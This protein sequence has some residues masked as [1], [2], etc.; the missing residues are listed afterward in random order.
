MK[1]NIWSEVEASIV[2]FEKKK[3]SSYWFEQVFFSYQENKAVLTVPSVFVK[4]SF[5]KK[6]GVKVLSELKSRG[7]VDGYVY[8]VDPDMF[9]KKTVGKD[10]GLRTEDPKEVALVEGGEPSPFDLSFFDRFCVGSSNKLAV[11]AAKSIVEKPGERFNPLFLYGK[12][13]VGKTYLLKTIE[14]T[15]EDAFYIGSEEFLNSFIQGIKNKELG[16]FKN[17]VRNNKILLFDDVQFLIG[18]KAAS[19]E[20][21]NT[22]NHYIEE[23]KSIVLVSDVRPEDLSGFPERLVSR[24]YSGLVTDI[25]KPGKDVLLSYLNKKNDEV[26]LSEELV[27]K[28]SSYPFSNFREI[29]GFLN[30]FS[31]SVSANK[32]VFSFVE[33]FLSGSS[34]SFIKKKSPEDLLFFVSEKYQVDKD[35]LVSKNRSEA[36]VKARHILIAL[37]RQNT[38]LSLNQIGLFLGGRSHSTVLSSLKKVEGSKDLSTDLDNINLQERVG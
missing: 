12:P 1:K 6:F 7:F 24:I 16:G 30:S 26:K 11:V 35:L 5:E 19:E 15:R 27:A 38:D 36:V 9:P 31:A 10:L 17:K 2:P 8:V 20:F 25:E 13:G 28:I 23:K 4:D 32:D 18:K 29:N 21:L 34:V 33:R 37:L 3:T 14:K 22:V